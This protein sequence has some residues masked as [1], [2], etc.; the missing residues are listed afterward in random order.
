MRTAEIMMPA[1]P[2]NFPFSPLALACKNP[3]TET[4][5]AGKELNPQQKRDSTD[6]MNPTTHMTFILSEVAPSVITYWLLPL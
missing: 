3:I 6:K 5:S 4:M 2:K 1:S